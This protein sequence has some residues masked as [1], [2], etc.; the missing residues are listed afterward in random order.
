MI[1]VTVIALL[2]PFETGG[3]KIADLTINSGRI[4]KIPPRLR[5]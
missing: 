1:F 3:Y 2:L 5:S 4:R